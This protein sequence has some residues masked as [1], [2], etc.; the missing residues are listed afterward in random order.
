MG[1]HSKKAGKGGGGGG[2]RGKHLEARK[3]LTRDPGVPDLKDLGRKLTQTA[4]NKT[5]SLSSIR[6]R[7]KNGIP[8]TAAF[9]NAHAGTPSIF[10]T[11]TLSAEQQAA[12][13][14]SEMTRLALRTSERNYEYEAPQRFLEG[15]AEDEYEGYHQ[16]E[17]QSMRR[18]FK[19]FQRVV[20]SCDVILQVVDARDP[21]GCRLTD[22]E[23]TIRSSYGDRKQIVL[24]LNKV[25]LLPSKEVVDAWVYYF[26][27]HENLPCIPFAATMK[28]AQGQSYIHEMFRRLRNMARNEENGER[29]AI[30]VGVI[31]YPN[32]G[33]SSII[34][35]L[36]RKN[37]VGVGN[38]PGFTT[39]NT[40]VE[41][42][43]DIR[44]MD[45][46]GVV[47]PGEDRG[48]V[49]LRNAVKVSDISNPFLPV[50][51]L[52]QRCAAASTSDCEDEEEEE[53]VSSWQRYNIHPL[54]AFYEIGHFP[55]DNTMEFIRLVG[56]RRGRL[57]KGGEVDEEETARMVLNDWNDGRIPYYTLPPTVNEFSLKSLADDSAMEGPEVMEY[58]SSG[59]TLD[60]LPTF[61]LVTSRLLAGRKA[62]KGYRR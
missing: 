42:R 53:R 2:H 9:R 14:R 34:N 62:K 50:E 47:A 21:L 17:E 46:P 58:L 43:S 45:C 57:L 18:F 40:E 25:D 19:E 23:Q 27:N 12:Q 16:H 28:G 15:G 56:L 55:P 54:A 6:G 8:S 60:G 7:Q 11:N 41:L 4:Q 35:A 44:V 24:V 49:I 59:L 13:R 29:K 39:G 51:R 61:H 38:M 10:S 52:L 37:V 33:K 26:E 30:V 22:V 31:G 1:G 5:H 32:V 36:K 20:E 48:D 3:K